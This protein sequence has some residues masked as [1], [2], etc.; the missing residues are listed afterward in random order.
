M[1][2]VKRF[3]GERY[4]S[5]HINGTENLQYLFENLFLVSPERQIKVPQAT[6]AQILAY[7]IPI[8]PAYKLHESVAQIW[9]GTCQSI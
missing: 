2:K 9:L 3:L 1:Q 5:L 8:F 6:R 7:Q 4:H